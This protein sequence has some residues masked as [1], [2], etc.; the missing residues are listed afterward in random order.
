MEH[1]VILCISICINCC[2]STTYTIFVACQNVLF[3]EPLAEKAP[4]RK[5]LE[6]WLNKSLKIQMTD[7]RTLIGI[8]S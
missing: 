3:Q 7:G 8:C 2:S 6:S 5:Q 1:S 4:G